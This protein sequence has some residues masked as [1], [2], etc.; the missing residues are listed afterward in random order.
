MVNF[1]TGKGTENVSSKFDSV[2]LYG[3]ISNMLFVLFQMYKMQQNMSKKKGANK[4]LVLQEL[5]VA[6]VWIAQVYLVIS[7]RY[8]HT[9]KVCSGDYAELELMN[10]SQTLTDDKYVDYFLKE[11]GD[12]LH[13]YMISIVIFFFFVLGL[14]CLIGSCLFMGGSFISLKMIEETLLKNLE[15]LP[16][17]MRRGGPGAESN[18]GDGY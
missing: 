10:D 8:S 5:I 15:Q 1:L 13:Y 16:E 17:M 14:A 11:E 18:A 9:G 12:F 6:L 3:F 2:I 4:Y 7:Y